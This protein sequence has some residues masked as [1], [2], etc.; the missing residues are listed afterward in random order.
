MPL[1]HLTRRHFVLAATLAGCGLA[2]GALADSP[3][4][5]VMPEPAAEGLSIYREW[6]V[7]DVMGGGVIDNTR[8][9]LNIDE[10]GH[11]SGHSGCNR[12][13]GQATI[14]GD[15]LT[16]GALAGTR[17]ACA[18]ALMNLEQKYLDAL[19][20]V[21][22]FRIDEAERKLVLMDAEGREVVR[23]AEG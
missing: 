19:G 2:T 22:S 4:A 13:M 23:L 15:K 8:L 7:E 18:E 21:A 11:A 16:F 3:E 20:K 6:V 9:T 1:P 10:A 14:D 12:F 5:P 17:M